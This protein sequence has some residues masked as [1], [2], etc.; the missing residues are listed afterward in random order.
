MLT[1]IPIDIR[2]RRDLKE[3]KGDR[4]YDALLTELIAIYRGRLER[5]KFRTPEKIKAMCKAVRN[6]VLKRVTFDKDGQIEV[7]DLG[8]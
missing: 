5:S 2:T 3:L 4:S 8:D 7:I 6:R 1:T